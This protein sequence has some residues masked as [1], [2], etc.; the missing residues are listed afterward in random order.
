LA[1]ANRELDKGER[2]GYDFYPRLFA[3]QSRFEFACPWKISIPI[4]PSIDGVDH[5]AQL[6]ERRRDS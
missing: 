6:Q 3:A 5:E 2:I 4:S 1:A